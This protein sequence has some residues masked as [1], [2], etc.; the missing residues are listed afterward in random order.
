MT[1]VEAFRKQVETQKYYTQ[2]KVTRVSKY[3]SGE[4]VSKS[5]FCLSAI[6]K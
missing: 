3:I 4:Y 5:W 6:L 1:K 2:Q